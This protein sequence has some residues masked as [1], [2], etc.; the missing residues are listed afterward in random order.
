MTQKYVPRDYQSDSLLGKVYLSNIGGDLFG[1]LIS[2]SLKYWPNKVLKSFS[3]VDNTFSPEK[4]DELTNEVST[5][6]DQMNWFKELVKT[7]IPLSARNEGLKNDIRLLSELESLPLER[8]E[9]PILV[10][11]SKHDAD[12]DVSHA[13]NILE[14]KIRHELSY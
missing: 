3:K 11:H 1:F 2:L 14:I 9:K 4:I 12:V 13:R 6:P 7:T 5:D 10:V 8:I